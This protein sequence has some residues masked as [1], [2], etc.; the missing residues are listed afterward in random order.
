MTVGKKNT[1]L[2]RFFCFVCL[3]LFRFFFSFFGDC[4]FRSV[5]FVTLY[6]S[7]KEERVGEKIKTHQNRR[8]GECAKQERDSQNERQNEKY[9]Y[10]NKYI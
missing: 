2:S 3:F 6:K 10:I 7:M 4:N 8:V 9:K 5:T 1:A